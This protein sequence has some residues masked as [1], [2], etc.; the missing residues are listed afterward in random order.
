M[1]TS[2]RTE[3][4]QLLE[5]EMRKVA[6]HV[7][8]RS[9]AKEHQ[10][11]DIGGRPMPPCVKQ[12]NGL[13]RNLQRWICAGKFCCCS[14]GRTGAWTARPKRPSLRSS[15]A[16]C[17]PKGL[18]VI[19]PTRLYGYTAEDENA[20]ARDRDRVCR[21]SVR[22]YYSGIPNARVPLDAGN[23]ERFGVSTTPTIVLVDRRGI[24]RLYHPGVM[25]EASLRAAI[26]PLLTAE[27]AQR[28]AR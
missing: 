20:A 7:A 3:A 9:S 16:N 13:A 14:S 1:P 2:K 5:S 25:D 26:E 12:R 8:R 23:F 19:A 15:R 6:R 18:V 22:A 24:V 11:V 4:L 28:T 27:H 21:Q 10:S 17:A